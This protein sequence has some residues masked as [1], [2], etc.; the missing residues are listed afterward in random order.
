MCPGSVGWKIEFVEMDCSLDG[1]YRAVLR[2][3]QV[4][5]GSALIFAFLE[6]V[7]TLPGLEKVSPLA[8][9][10]TG[11]LL[12]VAF[13]FYRDCLKVRIWII[14]ELGNT[15]NKYWMWWVGNDMIQFEWW[16]KYGKFPMQ[17]SGHALHLLS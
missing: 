7:L 14:T 12:G 16:S 6:T 5:L 10:S 4:G 15:L 13:S 3:L 9:F 2:G 8:V 11:I 17:L 1:I